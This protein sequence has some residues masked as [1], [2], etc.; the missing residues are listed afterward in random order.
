MMEGGSA[1]VIHRTG[2]IP[3]AMPRRVVDA[4][5]KLTRLTALRYDERL[6]ISAL[7]GSS[8]SQVSTRGQTLSACQVGELSVE[9]GRR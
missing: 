9:A 1:S 8:C 7:S 3:C 5:Q 6:E 4:A 2:P